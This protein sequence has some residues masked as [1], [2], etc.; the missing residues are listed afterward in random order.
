MIV[1]S[2]NSHKIRSLNLVLIIMVLYIHSYYTEAESCSFAASLQMFCGSWGLSSVANPLFYLLS[3][4]LFYKGVLEAKDCIPKI[5]TRARTLLLP[6]VLWNCIFVMWY[7]ILQNIPGVSGL[8]NSD[9]V[10]KILSPNIVQDLNELLWA[11]ANFPLW[12]VRDLLIMVALSPLFYYFLKYFKCFAP[13]LILITQPYITLHISP[14]FLLGGYIAMHSSLEAIDG[15][16]VGRG[17]LFVTAAIYLGYSIAQ[18]WMRDHHPYI[19]FIV[20]LCGIITIWKCYDYIASSSTISK[21]FSSFAPL[22]GYS[23]FIYLFHEPV[24]N[25]IKKIGLKVLGLHEWSLILLYLVNP[26][27]MCMVAIAFAKLLQRYTPK[28]YAV[29]VG[30]R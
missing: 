17:K 19:T 18:I 1:S 26:L 22:L 8:V 13:L 21:R 2:Y 29:L 10:G 24:F 11:P 3:G 4:F 30:G 12:F 16:L 14:F 25:I 6:Y 15:K 28:V 9:M 5:K 23:F 27:I 7:V 20:C